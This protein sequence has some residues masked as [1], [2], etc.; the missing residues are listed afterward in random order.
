MHEFADRIIIFY[1]SDFKMCLCTPISNARYI[2]FHV[3]IFSVKL[4]QKLRDRKKLTENRRQQIIPFRH[5]DTNCAIL[6]DKILFN[7][8]ECGK[9]SFE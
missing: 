4:L 1:V 8:E 7:V 9:N 6:A 2:Y 5:N 3:R